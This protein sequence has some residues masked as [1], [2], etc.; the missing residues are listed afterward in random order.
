MNM[1]EGDSLES[2]CL[3]VLLSVAPDA[4]DESLDGDLPLREQID[5]DSMDQLNVALGLQREFGIEIP[6]K[7][8]TRLA[9]LGGMV[10]YLRNRVAGQT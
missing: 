2:R 8:Y 1:P 9:S 4:A 10:A 7:D 3:N 5:F 6:E